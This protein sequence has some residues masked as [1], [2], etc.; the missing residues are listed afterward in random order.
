MIL[1]PCQ[2]D[3]PLKNLILN[4]DLTEQTSRK[5]CVEEKEATTS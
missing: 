1:Q 4:T 5:V 2:L 3:E